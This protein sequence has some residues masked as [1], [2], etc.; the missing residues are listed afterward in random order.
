MRPRFADRCTLGLAS[1]QGAESAREPLTQFVTWMGARAQIAISTKAVA[2]YAALAKS[3]REGALDV[4]W[5]PPVLYVALERDG[6][7]VPL[8]SNHRGGE[9]AF[10][11]VLLVRTNAP[12]HTL[13]GLRGLRAAW[14]DPCSASGYVMPR[15][16]LAA[17]GIDPRKAFA[18]EVFTGSHDAA[19]RAVVDGEADVTATFARIDGAGHVTSGSWSQV[20]EARAQVRVLWT[21]GAIPSDV[22]AAR[23]AY[24]AELRERI[25][26]ALVASTNDAQ[27][28]PIARRLFGVE[29]FRRGHM[30]S[31]ASLRRAIEKASASALI[32]DLHLASL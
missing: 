23:T 27:I 11:G 19:V 29:E 5:L 8:V 28:A 4:V 18:E 26:E 30:R 9:A 1:V 2:S 32:D 20:P 16:Q 21:L 6:L 12:I 25:T 24:P 15:I 31:Y 14:V 7:V 3:V 10:H 17:L 22:I 13:D